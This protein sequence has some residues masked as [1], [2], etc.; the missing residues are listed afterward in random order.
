VTHDPT[1]RQAV[2]SGARLHHLLTGMGRMAASR[3]ATVGGL[4]LLAYTAGCAEQTVSDGA[5]ITPEFAQKL[6]A[7][8]G[9]LHEP[10]GCRLTRF[11]TSQYRITIG[12]VA[13]AGAEQFY[14]G[15][16]CYFALD[17]APEPM[18]PACRAVHERYSAEPTPVEDLHTEGYSH[19]RYAQNGRGEYRIGFYRLT[20][21]T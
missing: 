5:A 11:D 2:E 17:G 12:L 3:L 7:R 6:Y 1:E 18:T 4:A 20:P 14:Q 19:L 8:V 13:A 9:P 21:Q 15:M 10:D 16:F